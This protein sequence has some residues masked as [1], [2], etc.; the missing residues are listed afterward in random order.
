MPMPWEKN[1]GEQQ[2]V[3]P[4]KAKEEGGILPWLKNWAN[5]TFGNAP[6]TPQ[7]RSTINDQ[8]AGNTNTLD[9]VFKRLLGAESNS[10]HRDK[11]GKLITSPVGA[12]GISQLMPKTA[13][14]PG[15]GIKPLQNDTEEEY[16]RFGK[17]YLKAMYDKFG[18]W[19][20]ALAGYNAGPG[21]VD[22]AIARAKE[23][24]GDWK[25]YLPKPKETLP[26]IEKI[27]G[28]PKER[29]SALNTPSN[30]IQ[31][32]QSI[33]QMVENVKQTAYDIA[34]ISSVTGEMI[35]A[36]DFYS[37]LKEGDMSGMALA[38]IGMIP[39]VG[40]IGKASK[41]GRGAD[42][43]K[44]A[45]Q[46]EKSGVKPDKIFEELGVY[47]GP[48][49]GEWRAVISDK[50]ARL[51][52]SSFKRNS[53]NKEILSVDGVRQL[54]N[55]LDHPEL[56]KTFPELKT[57]KVKTGFGQYDGAVYDET[58]NTIWLGANASEMYL[59]ST[60]LHEAQHAVQS[61]HKLTKGGSVAG[62]A[63]DPKLYEATKK[64]I[65]Q[66]Y[67]SSA[68]KVAEKF[69]K[70]N[71]FS[72]EDKLSKDI[73]NS[74]E[75]KR[76]KAFKELKEK[77]DTLDKENFEKYMRIGG[78]AEARATEAMF[79]NEV[80]NGIQGPSA[81]YRYQSGYIEP[82]KDSSFPLDFYDR[83]VEQLTASPLDNRLQASVSVEKLDRFFNEDVIARLDRSPDF[84]SRDTVVM[85][86]I[87]DFLSYAEKLDKPINEKTERI[88]KRYLEGD[89][90]SLDNIPFLLIN[91][92]GD[93]AKVTGHEGR[94]RALYLKEQGLTSIPVRV[95]SSSTRWSEQ[96][97]KGSFD[98]KESWPTKLM[99]QDETVVK[100]YPFNREGKLITNTQVQESSSFHKL[101]RENPER[102]L[103]TIRPVQQYVG[104][105]ENAQIFTL[106]HGSK[107]TEKF[108][109]VTAKTST[110]GALGPG[111]YLTESDEAA[112][113]YGGNVR[114]VVVGYKRP[115]EITYTGKDDVVEQI[116]GNEDFW[117]TNFLSKGQARKWARQQKEDFAGIGD[118]DFLEMLKDAGFDGVI[119]R[120]ES[121][122]IVEA[123][124]VNRNQFRFVDV[125]D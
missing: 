69:P 32:G 51:N 75:Y 53:Q 83:K 20:Q 31:K 107:S 16:L 26:Y 64:Q 116:A 27:L 72:P 74:Q 24:G 101:A 17:D 28:K 35:S 99:N 58:T 37:A 82:T 43:L 34:S 29:I 3:P 91:D 117:K 60:I 45:E 57:V 123:T 120:D 111:F 23:K 25:D 88:A 54:Q 71:Q 10:T 95:T 46:L 84:K 36:K 42:V 73:L 6:Q 80:N 93:I 81:Q 79:K 77:A 55:V 125:E 22:K 15:Y 87:D 13:G 5:E 59:T 19:E 89:K 112:K 97:R 12:K 67:H 115:L 86:P 52:L 21:N 39:G 49:D 33:G 110:D 7:N 92:S 63:A 76:F 96:T 94:H 2:Q 41:M 124:A 113:S 102:F 4:Q 68:S 44:K 108:T 48:V 38:G 61:S 104:D 30:K 121:G 56:F 18:D 122:K 109:H 114:E 40:M 119:M 98:Y 9:S 85:M 103:S 65:L 106:K 62:F 11:N 118:E 14:D 90:L 66:D 47:K 1:W 105:V 8:G 78:E 70:F 50:E 100:E